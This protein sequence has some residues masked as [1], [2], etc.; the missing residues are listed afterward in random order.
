MQLS[1][2]IA[3]VHK[4]MKDVTGKSGPVLEQGLRQEDLNSRLESAL[5]SDPTVKAWMENMTFDSTG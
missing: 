2:A 1:E 5:K 4:Y 3:R